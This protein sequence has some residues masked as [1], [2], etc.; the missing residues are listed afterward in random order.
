MDLFLGGVCFLTGPHPKLDTVSQSELV[1]KSGI[2]CIQLREKNATRREIYQTAIRLRELTAKYKARLIVNDHPD[3]ALA[4]DADG[5][6]LGQED[7]PLE[8]ARRI[9]GRKIIGISTHSMEEALA[10]ERGGADYIGV[11]PVFKTRT[12]DLGPGKGLFFLKEIREKISIPIMAIGGITPED[13]P[14]IFV[15]GANAVAVSGAILDGDVFE[16]AKRFAEGVR[17]QPKSP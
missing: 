15:A 13:L 5:V 14:D 1:L 7:F 3:I 2:K 8:D 4:A 12:K 9:M 10:A 11:G 17:K 6:H 16:N